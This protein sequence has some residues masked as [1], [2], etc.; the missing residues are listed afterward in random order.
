M[1]IIAST[2]STRFTL[3][4][5]FGTH[6]FLEFVNGLLVD[7]RRM[8]HVVEMVVGAEDGLES[9]AAESDVP[10]SIS[11]AMYSLVFL[12]TFAIDCCLNL[13]T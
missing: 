6:K 1:G 4:Y 12:Y 2:S 8:G 10:W 13:S 3:P 7:W 11:C 9:D 5:G